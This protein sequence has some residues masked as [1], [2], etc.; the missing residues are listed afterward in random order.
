M[1]NC[2]NYQKIHSRRDFLNKL[3]MGLGGLSL[4]SLINPLGATNSGAQPQVQGL[5]NGMGSGLHF[6]AR[7]KRVI[8]LFQSGG[9]SQQDLFD[10]KPELKKRYGEELPESVRQG[11]RLTGMTSGQGGF[12]L[13]G[14]VFDFK[15]HGQSGKWLS[16]RLPYLGQ[17][18]DDICWINSMHTDAIN[19]DPAVMFFQRY[20][21]WSPAPLPTILGLCLFAKSTPGCP[22]PGRAR[23]STIPQQ[24]WRY[25]HECS[26]HSA[27]QAP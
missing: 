23:P 6:P 13:A 3:G 2:H 4:A 1:N 11:Q 26:P 22:I 5:L 10:Y 12:P 21:R 25:Y 27:R 19:H 9:P 20:Q 15:Q 7:A 24:S 17:V 18:A 14:S 16:D 8:Y